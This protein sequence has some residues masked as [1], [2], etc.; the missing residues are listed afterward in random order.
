MKRSHLSLRI[1][2]PAA[3][4]VLAGLTATACAPS[5]SSN[6]GSNQDSKS[7]TVRVWL[8]REV[9]NSPKEK[10]V[11][12]AVAEFTKKHSGS[13]VD[14]TYIPIDTR[15]EKMKAAFNDPKSAPDVVEFGNTDT[16]GYVNDGGLADITAEFGKWKDAKQVT[17][18]VKESVSVGGKVYGVPWFV[19]VRALYYRTDI[20]KELGLEPPTTQD[21]LKAAARKIRAEHPDMFGISAGAKNV[22]G[23]LPFLWSAGGDL[24]KKDGDSY[25]AAIDSAASRK[26]LKAYTDLITKDICPPAQCAELG[27]DAGVQAFAAGKAGMAIGGDYSHQA[28]EGGVVK[29]KYAVVPLPGP[30][31]GVIPPAFAGGNNLGVMKSTSHRTLAVEFVELLGGANY[32]SK[33]FDAMGNMPAL[34]DV[35]EKVADKAPFTKPFVRT[36]TSGTAFVPVTPAWGKID[37]TGVIPTMMQEIVSGR[38]SVDAATADA[39]GK[40]DAAFSSAG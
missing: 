2:A 33:M 11:K 8:F 22:Y 39:A 17:A 3:A 27:G 9:N 16:A 34:S 28:M 1:A 12:E 13:R 37:S 23:M 7:G 24:A 26:G 14:V 25:T 18:S 5:T 35:Q 6:A 31:K 40:M 4:I 10:V 19:G 32:Q 29:G 15:A 20:F 30:K 21:E 38:K 36:L